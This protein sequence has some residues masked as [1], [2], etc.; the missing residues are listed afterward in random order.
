MMWW[1]QKGF[2]FYTFL[3][4]NLNWNQKENYRYW[5]N[6][7]FEM[8]FAHSHSKYEKCSYDPKNVVQ[9]NSSGQIFYA[10]FKFVDAG[11]K[12]CS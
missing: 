1:A 8:F 12:K 9:K 7:I 11:I 6:K 2:D 4:G 3:H 5:Q 10:D